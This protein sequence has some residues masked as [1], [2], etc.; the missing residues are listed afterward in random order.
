MHDRVA[1]RREALERTFDAN[2]IRALAK[3]KNVEV[4]RPVTTEKLIDALAADPD[5][6]VPGV[7]DRDS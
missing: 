2:G 1:A 6:N 4:D 5:V 7:D 3:A